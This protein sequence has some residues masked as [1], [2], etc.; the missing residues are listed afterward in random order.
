MRLNK[1]DFELWKRTSDHYLKLINSYLS[2]FDEP[3]KFGYRG[4]YHRLVLCHGDK[5]VVSGM[6]NIRC[7]I[8][9]LYEKYIEGKPSY[10]ENYY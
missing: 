10:E 6:C 9:K 4:K 2:L 7:Y 1:E 5:V 8:I 3:Y